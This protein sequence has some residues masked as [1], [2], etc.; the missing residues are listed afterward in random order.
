MNSGW[1]DSPP[2]LVK[3][4]FAFVSPFTNNTNLSISFLFQG[5]CC[6]SVSCRH[7]CPRSNTE[8][9]NLAKVE[10]SVSVRPLQI[11]LSS[12]KLVTQ[13]ELT[14]KK[15]NPIT[16]SHTQNCLESSHPPKVLLYLINYFNMELNNLTAP[17]GM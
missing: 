3:T 11:H 12:L 4:S 6:I 8:E 9:Q 7:L 5:N 13:V 1:D 10:A 15:T 2:S 14:A 16:V 17:S